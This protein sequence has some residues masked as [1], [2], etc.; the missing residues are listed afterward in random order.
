MVSVKGL[1]EELET[2]VR[3]LW[4][5]RLAFCHKPEDERG[6]YSSAGSQVFSST[7]EGENTDTDGSGTKS[8]S[9]RRSRRSRK[10]AASEVEKLPKLIETLALIYVGTLLMRHPT[11]LGDI[12]RWVKC[13]EILYNRAVSV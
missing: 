1:P 9:S 4:S 6:G 8:I 7:S 2:V 11:C 12:Y 5:L 10:S 13:D 3:D